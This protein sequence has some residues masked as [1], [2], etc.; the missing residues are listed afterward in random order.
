MMKKLMLKRIGTGF[1]LMIFLLT[2]VLSVTGTKL[3]A[4]AEEASDFVLTHDCDDELEQ[5]DSFEL[6]LIMKNLSTTQ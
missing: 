6:P 2:A 1:V 3:E 5:G 4:Y